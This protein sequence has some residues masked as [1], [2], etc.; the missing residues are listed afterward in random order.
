MRPSS[1]RAAGLAGAMLAAIAVIGGGAYW[2]L[3]S[4]GASPV[5]TASRITTASVRSGLP[6]LPVV[7]PSAAETVP[8]EIAGA[9]RAVA[10]GVVEVA[11]LKIRLSGIE[12]LEP[13]QVCRDAKGQGWRC[14]HR[15][16]RVLRS[17]VQRRRVTCRDLE[18]AEADGFA[19]RCE[20]GGRDL[21]SAMV[22]EGYA[23]A[24]GGFLWRTYGREESAAQAAKRGIWQ[25]EA[26]RPAAFREAKWAAAQKAAPAGCPIK[27]RVARGAK[28]YVVPWA[29]DYARVRVRP[30]RGERW[31]CSEAEAQAAGFMRESSG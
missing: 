5:E 30:A 29:P 27:G 10:G 28:V 24:T 21:A 18:S 7:A 25:G 2:W 15:A 17:L 20:A 4:P 9:G 3:S 6:P 8:D 13:G 14:G 12:A 19:G 31:F 1:G 26:E 22:T 16:E 23:F 11:G